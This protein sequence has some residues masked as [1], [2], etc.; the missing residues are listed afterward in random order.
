MRRSFKNVK[1]VNIVDLLLDVNNP[2]HDALSSQKDC[3]SVLLN[4]MGGK[5]VKIASHIAQYG[6]APEPII[7]SR[8]GE[9]WVVRD[10]NRRVTALKLLNNPDLAP[11]KFRKKFKNIKDEY[12]SLG[13]IVNKL[14][15]ITSDDEE[16]ILRCIELAHKGQQ[17]GIGQVKWGPIEIDMFRA[18]RGEKPKNEL[19]MSVVDY[20][21]KHNVPEIEKAS[22]TNIQRFFQDKA[23]QKKVGVTFENGKFVVKAN[24]EKTL[25]FLKEF[26]SDFGGK[27]KKVADI[28]DDKDR[29]K[30]LKELQSRTNQLKGGKE[31]KGSLEAVQHSTH[32]KSTV[33]QPVKVA[34][35]A[36]RE[37][38]RLI[39]RQRGLPIPPSETKALSVLNELAR[40]IDVREAPIAAGILVRLLLEFSIDFYSQRHGFEKGNDPL[41]KKLKRV[42][43]KMYEQKQIT[44]QQLQLLQ[45]MGKS[46]SIISVHTLNAYV[47]D[48]SYCPKPSDLCTFWDNIYY[49]VCFCWDN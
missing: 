15:C 42:A 6:L 32:S 13:N 23:V 17:D 7:I 25:R 37:R 8:K 14:D 31:E 18:I 26:A 39:Q 24:E 49:F 3:I 22:L 43:D 34:N 29:M 46:E 27:K 35:K 30:Y 36:P 20:L 4:S 11:I 28:Y 9:E 2:R 21:K 33:L 45:K 16:K 48:P 10:G 41:F 38:K 44:K 5:I 12:S 47:H 19:A 1:G 40:R